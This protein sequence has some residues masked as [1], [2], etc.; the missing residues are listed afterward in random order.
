MEQIVISE[1]EAGEFAEFKRQKKI[2]RVCRMLL[3]VECDLT[4]CTDQELMDKA[5]ICKD[6]GFGFVRVNPLQVGIAKQIVSPLP[7]I[8]VT[9]EKN[10]SLRTK[11]TAL[12]EAMR[13]G[14]DEV[15]VNLSNGKNARKEVRKLLRVARG[16]RIAFR[17]VETKMDEREGACLSGIPVVANDEMQE[18]CKG[19]GCG[20]L[21][22]ETNDG[23]RL[24]EE[25]DR[26][27]T[28]GFV[29]LADELFE[30]A[31]APIQL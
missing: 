10:S 30:E 15:V 21:T 17:I 23:K 6:R 25:A 16:K 26:I 20:T 3:K 22:V 29:S 14:A 8:C 31:N 1:A 18:Y 4:D 19:I 12:K 9:E 27:C 11:V 5:K 2:T 24:L 28:S 13:A 7:V